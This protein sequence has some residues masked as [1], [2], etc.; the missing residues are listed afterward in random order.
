MFEI[1]EL[2]SNVDAEKSHY[3]AKSGKYYNVLVF[4]FCMLRSKISNIFMISDMVV[5]FLKKVQEG[6]KWTCK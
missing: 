3:K 5:L 1:K 2:S 4:I 6:S